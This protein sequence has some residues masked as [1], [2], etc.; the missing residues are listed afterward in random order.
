[1]AMTATTRY[2][3]G[4]VYG[5]VAYDLDRVEQE[6]YELPREQAPQG[7]ELALERAKTRARARAR[8]REEAKA[9]TYGLPLLAM[10]GAVVAAAIFVLVLLGHVR[11]AD[12]SGSIKAVESDIA[13]LEERRE[14]LEIKHNM[15]FNMNEIET[16][17]VNILGMVKGDTANVTY[18]NVILS[19]R[20]EV[21]AK[22]ETATVAARVSKF[23]TSIPEYFR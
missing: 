22:D 9:N 3:S 11:L 8:A 12:V 1:M 5:S 10:V 18:H 20:G 4:A 21:L 14:A 6:E 2:A 17:A 19:D 15:V 23:V 13:E 16:Y 7:D